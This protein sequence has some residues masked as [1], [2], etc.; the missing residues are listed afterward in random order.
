M[1]GI[2]DGLRQWGRSQYR[3]DLI[4]YLG[5]PEHMD[6]DSKQRLEWEL[7]H[8]QDAKKEYEE[9][10]LLKSEWEDELSS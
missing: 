10:L 3:Q 6:P 7:A 4:E 5:D 8:N 9:L 2:V 1:S